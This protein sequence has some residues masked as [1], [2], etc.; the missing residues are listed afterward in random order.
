MTD[1]HYVGGEYGAHRPTRTYYPG[2][3]PGDSRLI[4]SRQALVRRFGGR[5]VGISS[6]LSAGHTANSADPGSITATD[7]T[8]NRTHLNIADNS[9]GSFN[10]GTATGIA[11][12]R[13]HVEIKR[14]HATAFR[15]LDD[16]FI[17]QIGGAVWMDRQ[18][19]RNPA[20]SNPGVTIG[21]SVVAGDLTLTFTTSD[22]TPNATADIQIL[23][24]VLEET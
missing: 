7:G 10:F 1:L 18:Y 15:E 16:L 21:V 12:I 2:A 8:W 3:R 11:A 4:K 19:T 24:T 6:T 20:G 17:A 14:N 23:Y 5:S 22:A 13:A 9:S